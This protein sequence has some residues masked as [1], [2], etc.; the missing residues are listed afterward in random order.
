[1]TDGL[2]HMGTGA[3]IYRPTVILK[4]E[5]VEMGEGSRI[6]AFVK[7]E[8][9]MGVRLGRFVHISSFSHINL[10]GGVL[11]MEDYSGISSGVRIATAISK[12]SAVMPES[13]A[14]TTYSFV[15]FKRWS[16]AYV[17]ALILPGVTLHEGACAAAGAVV[18]RDIPAWEVWGGC[19]AKRIGFRTPD[20]AWRYE[21]EREPNG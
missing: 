10:G 20:G 3:V 9:G 16:I 15:H 18:T 4:P 21:E 13:A 14:T 17:G 12:F 2:K 8:G 6:D 7:V 19:P 5:M 1:M 11:T